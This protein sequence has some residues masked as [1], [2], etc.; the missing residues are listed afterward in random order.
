M[1]NVRNTQNNASGVEVR[2]AADQ[3]KEKHTFV[4]PNANKMMVNVGIRAKI[5]SKEVEGFT[6]GGCSGNYVEVTFGDG[7][8]AS[9]FSF[10]ILCSNPITLKGPLP[11]PNPDATILSPCLSEWTQN[12]AKLTHLPGESLSS[13]V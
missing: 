1:S 2:E 10:P 8:N 13:P 11:E 12:L 9:T 7:E 3:G 5:K 4:G 6:E